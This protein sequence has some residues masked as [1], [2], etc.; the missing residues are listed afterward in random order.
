MSRA[1]PHYR[2][3]QRVKMCDPKFMLGAERTITTNADTGIVYLE[4]SQRGCI[5]DLYNEFK[6]HLTSVYVTDHTELTPTAAKEHNPAIL[7]RPWNP[8]GRSA[9][10]PHSTHSDTGRL[11]SSCWSTA[12][13][14]CT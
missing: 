13:L 10:A 5:D 9:A 3:S 4:L 8:N 2:C 14:Y 7:S 6:D 12:L 11:G 1:D